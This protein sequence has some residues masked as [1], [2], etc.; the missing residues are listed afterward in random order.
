MTKIK[1]CGLKRPEDIEI[2]NELKPDYCGFI[3]DFPKSHRSISPE[4]VKALTAKLDRSR[5]QVVGVFVNAPG[6]QVA[7][8]LNSGVI[9]MAQLHGDESEAYITRLRYM[10]DKKIIK[11]FRVKGDADLRLASV[12]GADHILL[13]AGQGSGNGFE[14]SLLD[15]AG[16]L[17]EKEWFLAGGLN[18]ENISQAIR[19]YHPFAVDLSSS[20]E[21]DKVKDR[22][23]VAR[24]IELVRNISEEEK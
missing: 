5:I 16:W 20:V 3:I 10:T 11:A 1:I 22:E 9:D 12:S 14:W 4:Q 2:V 19:K 15:G 21:T 23:K 8:L 7:D 24:I 18:E 6:K 13:D 17:K